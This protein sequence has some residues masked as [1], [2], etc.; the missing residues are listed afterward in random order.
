MISLASFLFA[1]SIATGGAHVLAPADTTS[2]D[3]KPLV[4][5]FVLSDSTA[6]DSV[7]AHPVAPVSVM[8]APS[9]LSE[10][11]AD[12]DT[13]HR[14]RRAVVLSDAALLR[15]RIHRYASYTV[16]P[17]F[18]L[19]AIAGNQLLQADNGGEERPGWAKSAHSFGAAAIGT[20]FTVNTV[21]GVWGLYDERA[22]DQNR[23]LRWAHSILMLASD[24]GFTYT[25]IKLADDAK[26]SSSD[27]D[28]HRNWAYASIGTALVGYGIM[29]FGNR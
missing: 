17:L 1:L 22:N 24:A 19:Q 9:L 23:A 27:R 2:L 10:R 14:R 26:R 13:V 7:V 15:L 3:T 4:A 18:A 29:F 25:G 28:L 8:L 21:T 20:V 5:E 11:L 12:A 16:I 6:S